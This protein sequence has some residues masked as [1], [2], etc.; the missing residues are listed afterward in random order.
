MDNC[1]RGGILCGAAI[2]FIQSSVHRMSFKPTEK[3]V[4]RLFYCSQVAT[5]I[6][7]GSSDQIENI[8]DQDYS[9]EEPQK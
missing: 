3:N 7:Y 8:T 1:C 5:K 2:L 4:F 9:S 6:N